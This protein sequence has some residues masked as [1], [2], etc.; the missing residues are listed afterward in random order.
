MREIQQYERLTLRKKLIFY[1]L[2]G[3]IIICTP[4]GI[5]EFYLR[6]T[7]ANI[8]LWKMTGRI[9]KENPKVP[10]AFIDAFSA[11][12]GR[13]GQ[14]VGDIYKKDA[15][16]T[17][18]Q[19]GFISTPELTVAK[20]SDTIRIVFLGGSSTAGTGFN[21]A[22][23]ATWP[24]QTV[25]MIREQYPGQ[26]I[27]FINGALSGYTSFESYGRLWSRIR[28]FSPDIIIV[29]HG[30][31]EMYYF[32]E[33]DQITSWRTNNDGSWEFQPVPNQPDYAPLWIDHLIR[34]SQL[35][36]RLR[37]RFSPRIIAGG[38]LGGSGKASSALRNS[39]D[40][41]GGGIWRTHL[42][43]FRAT[44]AI[45]GAEL[46]VVKQATL[47]VPNLPEKE[48]LRCNYEFHG[49]DHDAHVRAFQHIYDIIDE[50]IPADYIIDAT[51]L[52]G[53]PEYFYDHIHPTEEG[54]R[55][56]AEIVSRKLLATL[57]TKHK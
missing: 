12:R 9:P 28:F 6:I 35:L 53:I 55:R 4:F 5:T 3:L 48:R 21:L 34:P 31:N 51:P 16:K 39:Y 2:L 20:P 38:E 14:Y 30:W 22:D 54:A 25:Q 18:N 56:I 27:E 29:Y 1:M 57:F 32:N 15:V 46:F 50:E 10:W 44:A 23:N 33:V 49:F 43:L 17:V 26:K 52:S 47:I 7:C 24:W 37:R 13:P 42:Q 8:D 19:H 41:R 40:E 36:T 45:L 11:Y